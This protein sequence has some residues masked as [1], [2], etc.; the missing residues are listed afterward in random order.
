[1]G[2]VFIQ[3]DRKVIDVKSETTFGKKYLRRLPFCIL[4]PKDDPGFAFGGG[5]ETI[6]RFL[7]AHRS[8][9][10]IRS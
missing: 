10:G 2:K 4:A 7:E 8:R 5:D 9:S 1:M 6:G 3:N